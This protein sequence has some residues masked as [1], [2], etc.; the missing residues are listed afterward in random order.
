MITRQ[1][2]GA[3]SRAKIIAGDL[4]APE[5]WKIAGS[6]GEGAMFTF[7]HDPRKEPGAQVVIEK[8]KKSGVVVDGYTLLR[9]YAAA[10]VLAQAITNAAEVKS[11]R[12][13]FGA[14]VH[15]KD[16]VQD[17]IRPQ[18]AG[19]WSYDA[20]RGDVKQTGLRHP[21]ARRKICGD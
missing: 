4:S 5:F 21:L 12:K 13:G 10:Q 9:A 20:Q 16:A 7:P 8:L 18:H 15:A 2:H 19:K 1:M 17:T 3:G 11:Q 6:A 14:L